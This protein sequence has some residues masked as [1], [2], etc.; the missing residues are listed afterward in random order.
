MR[1]LLLTST[2]GSVVCMRSASDAVCQAIS[3]GVWRM[4]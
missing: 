4:K 2:T 1:S 3:S